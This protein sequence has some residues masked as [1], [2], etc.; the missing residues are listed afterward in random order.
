VLRR[1]FD[2]LVAVSEDVRDHYGPLVGTGREGIAVVPNGLPFAALLATARAAD[3]AAV[4]RRHGVPAGARVIVAVGRLAPEKDHSTLL[5]ALAGLDAI[6]EGAGPPWFAVVAGDGPLDGAL[7]ATAA[8][9]GVADRVRFAG[10]LATA[11]ILGL[12]GTSDLFVLPSRHEGH[13]VALAE[14]MACGL[15]CVGSD[16][17]GIRDLLVEG[18]TGRLHPPGDPAALA[19]VLA[20]LLVDSDQR[21]ALGGAAAQAVAAFD[22][23][24]ST[25]RLLAVYERVLAGRRR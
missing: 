25:D 23:A 11:D 6:G 14:A 15:A 7:R 4:R 24:P 5:A 9:L 17:T 3:P 2:A 10:R 18:R 20:E 16:T 8:R 13:P 12:L 1:S 19:A 22:L 21:A